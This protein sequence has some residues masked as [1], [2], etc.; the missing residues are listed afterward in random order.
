M[1]KNTNEINVIQ[2]TDSP[3]KPDFLV[4]ANN[5]ISTL[6]ERS[7]DIIKKRFGLASKN[8]ETLEK[9]G[10]DYNI[11]RERVRQIITDS[12]KNISRHTESENFS[13]A[14]NWIV[15]TIGENHGIIREKDIVSKLRTEDS[16]EEN[17]LRFFA[18]CS[19]KVVFIFEKGTL[20]KSWALSREVVESVKKI[21]SQV[22]DILEKGKKP[23]SDKEILKKIT[24]ILSDAEDNQVLNHLSI[25]VEIKKNV[26]GKWGLAYWDEIS[27]KGTRE[28]IYLVLK[29]TGK[30][31]HFTEI[32]ELIDKHKLG[33]RK[34]HPQTVHNELIKDSRFVLIGRG[35]YALKHWGYEEGTIRDVLTG[36]LEKSE[37][38][39]SKNELLSQVLKVRKVKKT[40]V[41]INLNN[42]KFFE[43]KEDLYSVKK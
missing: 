29:E 40:T 36:I 13:R 8:G 19:K 27:P 28:K 11:T 25:S 30:P 22:K 6:P 16:L 21:H 2:S 24:E 41:M 4:L 18:Q 3:E 10:K 39:L 26:F 7:R 12:I 42:S 43:K 1:L 38:P 33:K 34:A 37:K 32:A 5:L 14:E 31:L 23:L 15:F 17:A 9:I 35:I 20:E